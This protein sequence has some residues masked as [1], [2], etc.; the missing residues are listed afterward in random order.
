MT[1]LI[2]SDLHFTDKPREEFRWGIF[3]WLK[4]RVSETKCDEVLILGDATD[5]K[6]RHS[7]KLVNRMCEELFK[8]SN[9]CPVVW[10]AGNHDFFSDADESFFRFL[11]TV[12]TLTFITKP[13]LVKMSIGS[14]YFVPAG[15]KWDFGIP[16]VDYLFTH[17][18]FSGAKAE[19]GR[20]LTGVDPKVLSGFKGKV[21]SG[22]IHTP[23]KLYGGLVEY[24]GAP[25]HTRFGDE[26]DPRVLFVA[27]NGTT[28]DLHFP[29]PYKR[30]LT[31]TEPD[32]L[33]DEKVEKGDHVKVRCLLRRA[34]YDKWRDYQKEIRRVADQQGWVLCGSEPVPLEAT[35][36]RDE[37]ATRAVVLDASKLVESYAKG[38]KASKAYAE[39]GVRLLKGD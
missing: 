24:C 15:V 30:V 3:Q 12:E 28:K 7:S 23:Q 31:I 25:Y 10:L 13:T 27:N 2:T 6:D 37:A 26:Y 33:L 39:A 22:D 34:D 29:A 38:Q 14:A 16:E 35:S 4:N 8:L 19:N 18:T 20:T 1:A 9:Q 36:S 5:A 17:A 21:L 32:H 11:H